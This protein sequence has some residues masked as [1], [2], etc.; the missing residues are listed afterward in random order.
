MAAVGPVAG[1]GLRVQPQHEWLRSLCYEQHVG[2]GLGGPAEPALANLLRAVPTTPNRVGRCQIDVQHRGRARVGRDRLSHAAPAEQGLTI[3]AGIALPNTAVPTPSRTRP[4]RVT[5][6]ASGAMGRRSKRT[7]VTKRTS[8]SGEA[9]NASRPAL[10]PAAPDRRPIRDR[11]PGSRTPARS[12]R[13]VERPRVESARR[14]K[15]DER[16]AIG[17]RL[18]EHAGELSA[19]GGPADVR[20]CRR[21]RHGIARTAA[22]ARA[23]GSVFPPCRSGRHQHA[24]HRQRPRLATPRRTRHWSPWYRLVAS[25]SGGNHR[26]RPLVVGPAA[27]PDRRGRVR[28]APGRHDGRGAARLPR[29]RSRRRPYPDR[30]GPPPTASPWSAASTGTSTTR[31]IAPTRPATVVCHSIT[32]LA[33]A[34]TRHHSTAAEAPRSAGA[35]VARPLTSTPATMTRSNAAASCDRRLACLNSRSSTNRTPPANPIVRPQAAASSSGAID[36]S[37]I[38]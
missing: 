23:S 17:H 8:P 16:R 18:G 3:G 29:A 32:W 9:E 1:A 14:P 21:E 38:A 10:R 36:G 4:P 7:R 6:S 19:G 35:S 33:P 37:G 2:F 15:I 34:A 30:R 13:P 28:A 24:A 25:G 12:R 5:A 11:K 27:P 26:Q 20:P 22:R 31:A